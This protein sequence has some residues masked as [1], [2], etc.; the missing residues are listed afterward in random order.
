MALGASQA[1]VVR[2]VLGRAIALVTLGLAAGGA[3]SFWASRLIKTLLFGIEPHDPVT[4]AGAGILL[5]L[6]GLLA[7]AV[8]AWRASR[9]DPTTVMRVL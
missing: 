7:A 1:G 8:P 6:V 2:L 9:I 3:A 5:A 4:F